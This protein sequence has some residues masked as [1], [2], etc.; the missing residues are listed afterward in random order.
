MHDPQ[1]VAF[2]IKRPWP[3]LT[4]QDFERRTWGRFYWPSWVTIWHVDPERDGTD[5]SCGWFKRARH[6]DTKVLAAIRGEF[7]FSWDADYG[8]WFDKDGSPLM[9]TPGIVL[10]M[11]Y[12]A[13]RLMFRGRLDK[14][15]WRLGRRFVKRH[16]MDILHFA[17]NTTDSMDSFIVQKYGPSPREDRIDHA[18]AIVYG[19][20]LRWSQPWYRHARWHVW[21]WKI[22][23]HPLQTFKRWAFY[24]CAKCGRRF[25]WGYYPTS[26]SWSGTGPRW[27]RGEPGVY[28]GD[29]SH[30]LE[31]A[32]VASAV[33]LPRPPTGDK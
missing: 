27:F 17:E 19:C 25:A 29:C 32:K 16:I 5:D 2:D 28:H 14:H 20:L 13:S 1:T 6:G 11:F 18:A 9:S 30:P 23:V 33:D 7:A 31:S 4:T 15:G 10:D 24:R 8:G 12:R 26:H 3:R 22:Q 21:H